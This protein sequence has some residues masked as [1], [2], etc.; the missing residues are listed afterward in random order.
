MHENLI[1]RAF[2]ALVFIA[3]LWFTVIAV[4]R[5]HNYDRLQMQ[6]DA[7]EIKGKITEESSEAYTL[8]ATYQYS[9]GS[10]Q[11]SGSSPWG[12]SLYRNPWS[13][14]KDLKEF[15]GRKWKVWYDPRQ[16]DYSS[17]QKK[18]PLKECISSIA[19]WALL[20][21]FLGLGFYA[22]KMKQ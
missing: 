22:A 14:E 21:Y 6:T 7:V 18:F 13:A 4:Y 3:A 11:F 15:S 2:L 10:Q 12:D 16:P 1:W 19:L 8:S 5:Y 20:L 9:V 17:L